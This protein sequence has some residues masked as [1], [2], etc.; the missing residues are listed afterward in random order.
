MMCSCC[1][2]KV[3][4]KSATCFMLVRSACHILVFPTCYNNEMGLAVATLLRISAKY[5]MTLADFPEVLAE[6]LKATLKEQESGESAKKKLKKDSQKEKDKK[7][8]DK[9]KDKK[10]KDKKDKG[11]GD[12]RS[13]KQDKSTKKDAVSYSLWTIT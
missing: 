7:D 10:D 13:E 1:W 2:K 11:Q 4:L 5:E 8:K 3:G 6:K 12:D 9:D